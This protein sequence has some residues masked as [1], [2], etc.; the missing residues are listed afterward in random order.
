MINKSLYEQLRMLGYNQY[1]DKIK[2]IIEPCLTYGEKNAVSRAIRKY[3][4]KHIEDKHGINYN[5]FIQYD[6]KVRNDKGVEVNQRREISANNLA[7]KLS[8]SFTADLF[9]AYY[10]S[11]ED[12]EI[13]MERNSVRAKMLNKLVDYNM[14]ISTNSDP[15]VSYVLSQEISKY[16]IDTVMKLI[17]SDDFDNNSLKDLMSGLGKSGDDMTD[18]EKEA[19]N[20][21]IDAM[22]ESSISRMQNQ[23][24]KQAV[25]TSKEI[26][27]LNSSKSSKPTNSYSLSD[28]IKS[29]DDYNSVKH[30]LNNMK[31]SK[32]D[33]FIKRILNS[34]I[35]GVRCDIKKQ[36]LDLSEVNNIYMHELYGSE[37]LNKNF[38][39]LFVDE[40]T[41][42]K[43]KKSG[44]IDLFL[45]CSGSM[46]YSDE[47]NSPFI[48]VKS[49]AVYM[50]KK[51]MVNN[52]YFFDNSIHGPYDSSKII[53]IISFESGGGTNF[54]PIVDTVNKSNRR[55]L[56]LTDG[57]SSGSIGYNPNIYWCGILSTIDFSR[58]KKSDGES[59]KYIEN[60]KCA[61]YS[62]SRGVRLIS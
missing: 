50:I 16:I 42:K 53:D 36:H 31:V 55:S 37:F 27:S 4:L 18:A 35:S 59:V 29:V 6:V 25:E 7:S 24:I 40:I 45:D 19:V 21:M 12:F 23:S 49:L 1:N 15:I 32:S 17:H 13:N 43:N 62:E 33:K 20:T 54:K 10:A 11:E 3:I 5:S 30:I 39:R 60:N 28:S 57:E 48:R 9:N 51:N 47:E 41:V 38:K 2:E 8:P 56:V 22:D 52:V 14:R 34:S 58:F 61:N 26:S 44:K 46:G